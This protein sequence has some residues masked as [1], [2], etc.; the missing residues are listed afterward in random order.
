MSKEEE[1]AELVEIT[2]SERMALEFLMLKELEKLQE[3]K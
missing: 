1:F 2:G 3:T